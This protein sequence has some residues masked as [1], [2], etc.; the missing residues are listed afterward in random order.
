MYVTIVLSMVNEIT[1]T[2][3]K[4]KEHWWHIWSCQ[5]CNSSADDK[6]ELTREKIL[7]AAFEEIHH[8]GFQAASLSNILKNTGI[9]KGALYH[10][11][12]NKN[13]L[14]Y[15]VVDEIIYQ[16]VRKNWIEPLDDT[17]DPIST[18]QQILIESGE[19]M[20]EVDVRQGCPLNNLSL[21][22]SPIDENFR[23]RITTVYA[24]WQE[25]IEKACERAIVAGNMRQDADSKQLSLL[26]VATL[27]GCMGFA[28]SSQ[29]LETL[30]Q[31][32]HGLIT[33]LELLRPTPTARD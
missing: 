28:K 9:T 16:T 20:T 8:R 12:K 11:F 18:L 4:L 29:S 7:M 15:A 2:A 13:E 24:A 10:H 14:G 17:D 30:M 31:C 33:Q 23:Q 27:E 26:F 25:A 32:G 5:R 3:S 21:E 6:S 19:Q 22:M 1:S